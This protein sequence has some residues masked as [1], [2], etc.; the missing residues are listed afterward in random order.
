MRITVLQQKTT[1]NI[2]AI[3]YRSAGTALLPRL[4]CKSTWGH[5]TTLLLWIG[6]DESQSLP[7]LAR[8]AL[9]RHRGWLQISTYNFWSCFIQIYKNSIRIA[10]F[11]PWANNLTDD[12]HPPPSLVW[13]CFPEFRIF[14]LFSLPFGGT[15]GRLTVVVARLDCFASLKETQPLLA[16]VKIHYAPNFT[17]RTVTSLTSSRH[18]WHLPSRGLVV[19]SQVERYLHIL[20]LLS[21]TLFL[22]YIYNVSSYLCAHAPSILR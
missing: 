5:A 12:T 4:Y 2:S 19:L 16:P 3:A 18:T 21:N 9:L 8:I 22:E 10:L 1:T 17:A 15:H 13:I 20:D 6:H 7:K 14:I 11:L